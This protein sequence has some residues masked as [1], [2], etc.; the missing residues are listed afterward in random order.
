MAE[1]K[2]VHIREGNFA[3]F[4]DKMAKL[5]KKADKLVGERI[6][7]TAVGFHYENQEGAVA[8]RKAEK[9]LEV[10]VA[11]PEIKIAGWEFIARIDHSTEG[12]NIIRGLNNIEVP[13]QYREGHPSC[14]HCGFNRRRRDTFIVR[15]VETLETKQVG[16]TCLKDFLG[17][18][19]ADRWAKLA[20]VV[21]NIDEVVARGGQKTGSFYHV[22]DVQRFCEY[23]ASTVLQSGWM[24][25]AQAKRFNKE[26]TATIAFNH[27]NYNDRLEAG[28]VELA[29]EAIAWAAALGDDGTELSDYEHN[30][31]V[32]A[33]NELMEAKHHGLA[34]S[35]V[36]VYWSKF[37]KI[38]E[39]TTN[40]HVGVVGQKLEIE[41]NLERVSSTEFSTRH[42]FRDSDGRALVW[43]ASNNN[44][45]ELKN[46]KF[47]IVGT[48]KKHD[49]Y[50]GVKQTILTRVKLVD[51]SLETI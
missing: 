12:G 26:S 37:K 21:F 51:S 43:F 10:F 50:K 1:G 18:D 4:K 20:E 28:S 6:Y 47:K 27:E 24:S 14:E 7:I 42:L 15:N 5:A 9:I 46:R 48:V 39:K 8:N 32:I 13:H 17:H 44:Y 49:E 40:E 30:I 41:V 22:L 34:A 36:G 23:A 19:D 45:S 2:V 11:V 33:N 31:K 16:T 3:W 35:I 25:R 29:N 38:T